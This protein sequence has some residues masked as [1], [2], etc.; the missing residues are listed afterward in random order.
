MTVIAYAYSPE[1]DTFL[2]VPEDQVA[3]LTA[4]HHA[5]RTAETWGEFWSLLPGDERSGLKDQLEWLANDFES[6]GYPESALEHRPSDSDAFGDHDLLGLSEGDYP[7]II[8]RDLVEWIPPEIIAEFGTWDSSPV[9]GDYLK[10]NPT[11]ERFPELE[12]AFAAHGF[13][14]VH[15]EIRVLRAAGWLH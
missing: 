1:D 15:D 11:T 14:L 13:R 2:F 4:I 6:T 3:R 5:L 12:A 8:Q 9:S 10:M 7:P